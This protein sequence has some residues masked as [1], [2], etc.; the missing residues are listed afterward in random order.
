MVAGSGHTPVSTRKFRYNAKL[1]APRAAGAYRAVV[2]DGG[3][4]E[5]SDPI[6]GAL[7]DNT[8]DVILSWMPR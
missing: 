8:H 7:L 5:V 4:K 2:V 3:G 1:E 6:T